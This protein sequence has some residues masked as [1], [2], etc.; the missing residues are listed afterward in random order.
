MN[1]TQVNLSNEA[2]FG[3]ALKRNLNYA[4]SKRCLDIAVA[5]I[6][7]IM[8]LP[9]LT[10]VCLLVRLTARG[11]ALYWQERVGLNGKVIRF[12]KIR[13]MV[14][15]ADS[16][17]GLVKSKNKHKCSITFKMKRDPRVTFIGRF[18]RKFSIDE[19]PQLW[20]VLTGELSL[21]GPRPALVREVE[22]YSTYER[23]R[24]LVKPGLTCIWQVSGRGDIAFKE[25]VNMDLAYISQRSL[26]VDLKLLLL[27]VPAVLA[28][29][30]AY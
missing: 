14:Q 3:K 4:L 28:G 15:G 21:V 5:A 10:V 19:L 1:T 23:Q 9:L 6:A 2:F 8:L 18:I 22:K 29:K 24:L 17:I 11:K 27:T 26:W 13:S 20:L 12:P 16:K 25:Q 7:L 30:G